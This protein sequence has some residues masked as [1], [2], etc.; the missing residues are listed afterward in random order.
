VFDP[1][2]DPQHIH[3]RYLVLWWSPFIEFVRRSWGLQ[4]PYGGWLSTGKLRR[5]GDIA[6]G[7]G[8]RCCLCQVEAPDLGVAPVALPRCHND[9]GWILSRQVTFGNDPMSLGMSL[10]MITALAAFR[11]AEVAVGLTIGAS[12]MVTGLSKEDKNGRHSRQV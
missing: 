1:N 8:F 9:T 2:I 12:E 5:S 10:A 6:D 3:F 11:A 7:G 4:R